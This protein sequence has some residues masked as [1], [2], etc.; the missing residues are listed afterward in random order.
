MPGWHLHEKVLSDFFH[1]QAFRSL[2]PA[3]RLPPHC[4]R[5]S[6]TPE[7]YPDEEPFPVHPALQH[8]DDQQEEWS[9]HSPVPSDK[10]K[11]GPLL[12]AL[13]QL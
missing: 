1:G 13:L 11:A 2:L 6:Q 3:S 7:W 9:P 10:Q 12:H 8:P 4:S 5:T